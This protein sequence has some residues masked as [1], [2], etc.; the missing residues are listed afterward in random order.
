MKKK[1]MYVKPF[2]EKV[3]MENVLPLANGSKASGNAGQSEDDGGFGT[4]AKGF[5]W[6]DESDDDEQKSDNLF[7]GKSPWTDFKN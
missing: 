3:Y 5:S 4:P 7:S 1:V 6:Y 2:T